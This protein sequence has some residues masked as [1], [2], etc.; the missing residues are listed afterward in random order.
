[1]RN[2]SDAGNGPPP[3]LE[4]LWLSRGLRIKCAETKMCLFSGS[5]LYPRRYALLYFFNPL[6]FFFDFFFVRGDCVRAFTYMCSDL[7]HDRDIA[8][9]TS[10][11]AAAIVELYYLLRGGLLFFLSA[12]LYLSLSGFSLASV[13]CQKRGRHA[14]HRRVVPPASDSSGSVVSLF[15]CIFFLLLFISNTSCH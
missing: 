14:W 12:S 15:G 1:M 2:T 6:D 13:S 10:K 5:A 4:A 9:T 7:G 8:G 11:P 3:K